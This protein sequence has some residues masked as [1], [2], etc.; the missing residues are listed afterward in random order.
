MITSKVDNKDSH[1]ARGYNLTI[2]LYSRQYADTAMK[3]ALITPTDSLNRTFPIKY[4]VMR[5]K[6]EKRSD[7]VLNSATPVPKY[8]MT[9][10]RMT[11]YNG[12]CR[13]SDLI[14]EIT[15]AADVLSEYWINFL[16]SEISVI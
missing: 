1:M 9:K 12:G 8:L 5:E 7:K 13:R 6:I 16:M 10:C 15:S 4:I 3:T 11:K 2:T 14:V